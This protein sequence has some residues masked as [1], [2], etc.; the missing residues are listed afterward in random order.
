MDI[1][2]EVAD[3]LQLK[4]TSARA[5]TV[6]ADYALTVDEGQALVAL[7]IDGQ[8]ALDAAART[9]ELLP[10]GGTLLVGRQEAVLRPLRLPCRTI[11]C[12]YSLHT[13]LLHPLARQLPAVLVL[14][15][16]LLTDLTELGRG[17]KMLDDEL[18]NGRLG[19]EFVAFRLAEIAFIEVLRRW[20]L[21]DTSRAGFLTALSDPSLRVSLEA[22][23]AAPERAWSVEELAER[24]TL[25]RAAFA[26]RFH[27]E[28]GEP[29]LRY[30]RLWRLLRARRQI[31]REGL[32][33]RDAARKAGYRTA[34]GFS[35]AFRRMFGE[36]PGSLRVP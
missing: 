23:H 17:V 19:V 22:I 36:S 35:R 21:E 32:R 12:R 3:A 34:N 18:T 26:E 1:L 4:A 13:Q 25:S 24:A 20:Q 5:L 11:L 28:V 29:P 7:T 31:T 14:G 10:D 27:R 2:T 9:A 6:A 15:S 30:V 8:C 33:V 16:R